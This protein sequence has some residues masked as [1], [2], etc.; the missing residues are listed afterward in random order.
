MRLSKPVPI[1]VITQVLGKRGCPIC[2]FLKNYQS[3]RL[4]RG[5]AEM[6]GLCNFHGWALAA[7]VNAEHAAE[8]FL[9][10]LDRT[11]DLAEGGKHSACSICEG[12]QEQ[13]QVRIRELAAE[14]KNVMALRWI[15]K[16]G[17]LCLAH[18]RKLLPV[19]PLRSRS[20]VEGAT[21]KNLESLRAE[22]M[23]VI[24]QAKSGERI[25]GGALGHAA[26]FLVSQRGSRSEW[27]E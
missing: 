17:T 12:M 25:S 21:K 2:A 11:K 8:V 10:L 5:P 24:Q 9:S 3:E 1:E 18:L 20:I 22:L 6:R 15:E 13:E 16:H 23:A 4:R 7:A 14:L 26:E 27:E 19:L